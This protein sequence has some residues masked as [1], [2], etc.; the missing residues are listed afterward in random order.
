MTIIGPKDTF[1]IQMYL[2]GPWLG[3]GSKLEESFLRVEKVL[4]EMLTL[5]A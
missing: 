1:F 2:M 5:I 3:R 4:M